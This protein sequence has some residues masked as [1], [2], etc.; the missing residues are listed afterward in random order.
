[1]EYP[2]FVKSFLLA[3]S[4][5]K[6]DSELQFISSIFQNVIKESGLSQEK[7]NQFLKE[8]KTS[9][10]ANE[11]I[12]DFLSIGEDNFRTFSSSLRRLAC[13]VPSNL[14]SKSDRLCD[15]AAFF[16]ANDLFTDFNSSTSSDFMKTYSTKEALTCVSKIKRIVLQHDERFQKALHN[17]FLIK[18]APTG[19]HFIND[20]SG[21]GNRKGSRFLSNYYGSLSSLRRF[22]KEI[23]KCA[24]FIKNIELLKLIFNDVFS[25][26]FAKYRLGVSPTDGF[27]L[28]VDQKTR[29][30]LDIL[31]SGELNCLFVFYYLLFHGNEKGIF[32]L[33]EPEISLHIEW[34]EKIIE[35]IMEIQNKNGG[36]PQVIIATHSP[37]ILHDNFDLLAKVTYVNND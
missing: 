25:D 34:Q 22:S 27:Y 2:E 8:F 29:L 12:D 1:M 21:V 33:D 4:R 37:F 6:S 17:Y 14:Y 7:K 18:K 26:S 9:S 10:G 24:S 36:W 13:G 30:S 3:S 32:L 5:L 20:N 15:L 19:A 16:V 35:Q 11:V 28:T 31:P 23:T